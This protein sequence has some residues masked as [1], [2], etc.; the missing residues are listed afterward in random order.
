MPH[1]PCVLVTPQ[2]KASMPHVLCF[3]FLRLENTHLQQKKVVF[4]MPVS[5]A[6]KLPWR[7]SRAIGSKCPA[8]RS[9]STA[10][11]E[12]VYMKSAVLHWAL[13]FSCLVLTLLTVKQPN[14]SRWTQSVLGRKARK[15]FK[16]VTL[17]GFVA[18]KHVWRSWLLWG[19]TK[20][21]LRN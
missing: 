7:F 4:V 12:P 11:L 5:R 3:E 8:C 16:S 17:Q 19:R 13:H 21:L 1:S 9:K 18:L 20:I 2:G 6:Q 15:L 10:L 14:Q